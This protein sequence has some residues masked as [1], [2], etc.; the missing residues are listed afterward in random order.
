MS[1]CE[2]VGNLGRLH[3]IF[4]DDAQA[5]P[6]RVRRI[7]ILIE[8]EGVIGVQPPKIKMAAIL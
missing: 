3:A 4:V 8:R 6:V 7:V 5:A 1:R 2:C